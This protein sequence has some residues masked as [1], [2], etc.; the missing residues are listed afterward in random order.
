M[1]SFLKVCFLPLEFAAENVMTQARQVASLRQS[2][3]GADWWDDG[4]LWPHGGAMEVARSERTLRFGRTKLISGIVKGG[5]KGMGARKRLIEKTK[6]TKSSHEGEERGQDKRRGRKSYPLRRRGGLSDEG[7]RCHVLLTRLE[8]SSK[9]KDRKDGS[10]SKP[11]RGEQKKILPKSNVKTSYAEYAGWGGLQPRKRRLASLN[12]EAVNSLLLERPIDAQ[13]AA[14]QAK[15]QEDSGR[16][17]VDPEAPRALS[18]RGSV[19]RTSH[20]LPP[21]TKKAKVNR[22]DRSVWMS[23]EYLDAPAPRRLAGLNAAALLKLTSSSATSKQRVKAT[24]TATVTSDGGG[25]SA[26]KHHQRAKSRRQAQK[27]KKCAPPPGVC[28]ACKKMTDYEPE[29]EWET[30]SCTHQ[31]S[32]PG[33]QPGS[34]L[35][36][37]LKPVKEEQLEAELSPFYCCPPEGSVEYCHRLAFFLSQQP[38]SDS[39]DKA[40]SA[41]PPAV[42]RECLA[43]PTLPHSHPHTALTLSHHPCLCTTDPCYSSYYVHIAHP[44]HTGAPSATLATPPLGFTPSR[45]CPNHLNDSKLLGGRVSHPAGL[46]HPCCNPVTSACCGIAGY[47]CNAMPPVTSRRCSFGAGCSGC[48]RSIKTGESQE[49][50]KV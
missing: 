27:E 8:E 34:L 13:P 49:G 37:P 7:R 3:S 18:L 2:H 26:P 31:V 4:C 15:T 20:K 28:K 17:P 1:K 30:S 32:K 40:L 50:E 48:R 11:K 42:K 19:N 24:P 35:A 16:V 45:L 39:D 43:P 46:T 21:P 33:Y 22:R 44:T 10:R 6:R 23:P 29:V 38:Y 25:G 9:H 14:K 47:A 5:K 12:A 36:Y 41:A